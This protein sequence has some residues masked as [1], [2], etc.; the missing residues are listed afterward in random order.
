MG[1]HPVG[2]LRLNASNKRKVVRFFAVEINFLRGTLSD[3]TFE[4]VQNAS[5]IQ[6]FNLTR[7]KATV[8]IINNSDRLYLST[9]QYEKEDQSHHKCTSDDLDPLNRYVDGQDSGDDTRPLSYVMDRIAVMQFSIP[10]EDIIIHTQENGIRQQMV[11]FN[12]VFNC[13]RVAK[14]GHGC[15]NDVLMLQKHGIQIQ[16]LIDVQIGYQ[17]LTA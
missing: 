3:R 8:R 9:T 11:E 1:T 2:R 15:D 10:G 7:E 5:N 17:L 13:S 4:V 6:M 16:N 14:I 12:R